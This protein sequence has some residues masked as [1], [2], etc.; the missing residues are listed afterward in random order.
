MHVACIAERDRDVSQITAS[1]GAF[2]GT[3]LEALIKLLGWNGQFIGQGRKRVFI[4][5]SRITLT[6][7]SIPR[8][9]HLAN[10][11][12]KNPIADFFT[13]IGRDIIFEFDG[14]IGDATACVNGAIRKDAIRGAGFDATPAGAAVIGDKRWIRLKREIKKNFGEQKIGTLLWINKTGVPAD[15]AD[16]SA[17]GKI[18]LKDGARVRVPAI[19]Y[20]T[21]DLFFDELNEFFHPSRENIV[22]VISPGVG[23][24]VS[25]RP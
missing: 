13:Q 21:P 2:D 12:S 14:E 9:N 3:P 5:K 22:I 19:L 6:C 15:P 20:R 11:T 7:E 16:A 1:F 18:T 4:P 10:V 17:L 25:P 24:D 23:G 8:T